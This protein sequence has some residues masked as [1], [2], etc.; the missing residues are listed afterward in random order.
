MKKPGS[1][2]QCGL[3]LWVAFLVIASPFNAFAQTNAPSSLPPAAQQALDKGIIAAKVPDYPLAIRYFEDARKLVPQAP[4]VFMNLGIAESKIPGRELRA[5]AWFG[6]YL[7][8]SP[9]APNAAAVK[10]QIAVL[11]VRQQSNVARLLKTVQD[12]VDQ[13]PGN[14]YSADS[15]RQ[16]MTELLAESGDLAAALS[17]I[18]SMG[19]EIGRSSAQGSIA[20][21]QAKA[22][23]FASALKTADIIT[24][25]DYKNR[26]LL[27]IGEAQLEAKDLAGA[28][29]TLAQAEKSAELRKGSSPDYELSHIAEAQAKADDIA[30]AQKTVTQIKSDASTTNPE[31]SGPQLAI[32]KAQIRSGDI[33]GALGTAESIQH[34]SLKSLAQMAIAEK[35]TEAGDVEA[36]LKTAALIQEAKYRA[37]AQKTVVDA[38]I[39]AG[40]FAGA[41]KIA[42]AAAD[43]VMRF[44][45]NRAQSR[46]GDIAGAQKS[47]D[48]IRANQTRGEAQSE[49]ASAQI[50]AGDIAGA[51]KTADAI[52]DAYYK[53]VSLVAIAAAQGKAGDIVAAMKT[54]G[55]IPDASYKGQARRAI[56][57]AQLAGRDIAGAERTAA[58]IESVF[59]RSTAQ[60]AIAEAQAKAGDPAGA[61]RTFAEAQRNADQLEGAN[62]GNA[63]LVIAAAEAAAGEIAE[64]QKT[65]DRIQDGYYKVRALS[66]VAEAQVRGGNLAGAEKT[67]TYSRKIAEQIKEV[68]YKGYAQKAIA[69]AE[70]KAG[71]ASPPAANNETV[72]EW[73][74]KLED[75]DKSHACPLNTGP[76]LDLSGYLKSLPPSNDPIK[77][78]NGLRETARDIFTAQNVVTGMLKQQALR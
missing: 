71:L 40:D 57:E 14:K 58:A 77:V 37:S 63:T 25:P 20:A 32:V 73:L 67:L 66:A 23:D 69:A 11:E 55:S 4:V 59:Y 78:F 27:A 54:A 56:V 53:N 31:R 50:K 13:I 36:A 5:I 35:Q 62:K 33:P 15:K 76:F 45:I 6:A 1:P 30:G 52:Q 74:G 2:P 10:E 51:Q 38:Q 16:V 65:A 61:R 49:I 39:K 44:S 47:I 29:R 22:G 9:D 26:A 75:D 34:A 18:K 64:A 7:A 28:R 12:A 72:A 8:A 17:L 60:S 43:D 24:R 41:Q 3:F 68:A 70:A 46:A 42:D 19:E 21:L 48:S